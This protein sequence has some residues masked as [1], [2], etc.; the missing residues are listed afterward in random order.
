MTVVEAKYNEKSTKTLGTTDHIDIFVSIN[1]FLQFCS[2]FRFRMGELL[3]I[4]TFGPNGMETEDAREFIGYLQERFDRNKDG[5]FQY[6]G[7]INI[8]L[9]TILI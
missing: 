2:C 5:M 1:L 4:L 3:T 6:A 8:Y 7:T 9:G